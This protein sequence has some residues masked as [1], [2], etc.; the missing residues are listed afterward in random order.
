MCGLDDGEGFL[1][2]A[3]YAR[4][5]YNGS[6]QQ[7][8]KCCQ[9]C[10]LRIHELVRLIGTTPLDSAGRQAFRLSMKGIEALRER[11][12]KMGLGYRSRREL[13]LSAMAISRQLRFLPQDAWVYAMPQHARMMTGQIEQ[14]SA[15]FT[16]THRVGICYDLCSVR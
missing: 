7:T 13:D 5:H 12:G 16:G 4:E 15:S 9:A 3:G 1:E 8:R 6:D 11:T 10:P 2:L 14:Y